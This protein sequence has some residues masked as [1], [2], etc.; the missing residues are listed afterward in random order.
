MQI[1][2]DGYISLAGKD[3]DASITQLAEPIAR[4]REKLSS[5]LRERANLFKEAMLD[6]DTFCVTWEHVPGRGAFEIQQE[7]LVEEATRAARGGKVHAVSVTDNPGGNPAISTEILCTELK[8]LGIEPLVHVAFR[9]K[10]RNQVESLLYGVAALGVRNL[11]MLTGDYPASGG[12]MGRARPNFD[13]D[14][15]HGLQLVRMMN[16]GLEHEALGRKSVLAPTDFFAGAAVSPFKQTEAELMGQYYKLRKKIESGAGFLITQLGYDIRKYH[17][18]MTWL[19]LNGYDVPAV[20]NIYVLP[21]A[22]ART[23][24]ANQIPGAVV[25]AKLLN[26][27]DAERKGEDKGRQ[28]RLMRAARMYA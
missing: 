19:K 3:G 20:I 7:K 4:L 15:V 10:N 25:T 17:E 26:E 1:E 11:L 22:A 23:M 14:S 8:K 6:P 18:L 2:A 28:A 5:R 21:Y 13:L 9:D 24:N 16:N 27:I 12:F